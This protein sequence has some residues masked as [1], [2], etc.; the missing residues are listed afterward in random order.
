MTTESIRQGALG[1]MYCPGRRCICICICLIIVCGQLK[2]G[3]R[4]CTDG[5]HLRGL[6]AYVNMTAV[7]A[8]PHI[9]VA[10][11]EDDALLQVLQKR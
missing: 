8:L 4:V 7:A 3:L 5:T 2:I 11:L 10:P 1:R 9:L 6:F